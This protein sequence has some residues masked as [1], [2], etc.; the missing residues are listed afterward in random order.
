MHPEPHRRAL[1]PRI[2][3]AQVKVLNPRDALHFHHL[4]EVARVRRGFLEQFAREAKAAG[5]V[6]VHGTARG[7]VIRVPIA[8]LSE[9][10]L[11]EAAA[12][13]RHVEAL[14]DRRSHAFVTALCDLARINQR[15]MERVMRIF[16]DVYKRS[17]AR[18]FE[19]EILFQEL[20]KA[21]QQQKTLS[22]EE[23]SHL[24]AAFWDWRAAKTQFGRSIFE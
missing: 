2:K 10:Q 9:V 6:E 18:Q 5:D 17:T 3:R 8:Q 16:Q 22:A 24:R 1:L 14:L 4:A 15:K 13:A 12:S 7:N 23:L 20:E 19:N 21:L 11:A